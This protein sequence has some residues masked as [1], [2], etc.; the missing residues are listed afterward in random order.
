MNFLGKFAANK[1]PYS[2]INS[3]PHQKKFHKKIKPA[4]I[5]PPFK[6]KRTIRKNQYLNSRNTFRS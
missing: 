4:I 3:K 5:L 2:A 1:T 6:F